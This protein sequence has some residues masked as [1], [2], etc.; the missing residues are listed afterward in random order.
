LNERASSGFDAG[1]HGSLVATLLAGTK[2]P[3]LV[4]REPSRRNH[5]RWSKAVASLD[6]GR[7][8]LRA[9]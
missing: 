9:Q 5:G 6:R 2:Y 3:V 1:F 8:P 4:L 7:V